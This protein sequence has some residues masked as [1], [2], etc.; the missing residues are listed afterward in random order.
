MNEIEKHVLNQID[1]SSMLQFLDELVAIQS[2]DGTDEENQAQRLV[3]SQLASLGFDV[4]EWH[5]DFDTLKSHPSYSAEVERP[6]G[7]GVVG[8]WGSGKSRSLLLN[9]HVDVVPPGDLARWH[10]DPWRATLN[11]ESGRVYGR[12]ALDMKG[13]LC[14]AIFAVQ[15]IMDAGV[16]LD[17]RV[18]IESVIGEED[19]GCGTLAAVARGHR[20]DGAVIMEP[21]EL[22]IAPA[23]AGCFNFRIT[24][25]GKAAHGAM[26]FEGVDPLEK[27][28][29]IYQAILTYE[30]SRNQNVTHPLFKMYSAPYPICC[31]TIHGGNWASTVAESLTFEGRY[32]V[33]PGEDHAQVRAAFEQAIQDV[34]E[35]DEWLREHPLQIEWWGGQFAPAE[36]AVEHPVVTTAQQAFFEVAGHQTPIQGMTY[37]ADMRLLVNDGN[38]PTILFGPGD[39][40][41]AHRP[42]EYVPLED[43]KTCT[44]TL[45]LMILRFCDGRM[46]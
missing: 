41:L 6:E 37:G 5:I 9:G 45:A 8:G 20:A 25:P 3:A 42:N 16:T 18:L 34:V 22:M 26:R 24:I 35:Q 38:I 23:Q 43:L 39:V 1:Y 30:H 46:G 28:I 13:G 10:V 40:R 44:R 21:T 4:D 29:H 36:I 31:G 27:F 19:G 2:L 32:G 11:H 7:I 17:G 33:E 14:C 12:G 15:A